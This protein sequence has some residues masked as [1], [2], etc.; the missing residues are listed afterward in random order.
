[1]PFQNKKWNTV[2]IE[3]LKVNVGRP[4]VAVWVSDILLYQS[5]VIMK[6]KEILL[7]ISLT[8]NTSQKLFLI[9]LP[10]CLDLW[11]V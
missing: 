5:D 10:P 9:T 1:M 8:K 2:T 3:D 4:L 6:P 7:I 11:C